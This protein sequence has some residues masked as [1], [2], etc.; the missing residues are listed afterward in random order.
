MLDSLDEIG[1]I[2][3]AV[4]HADEIKNGTADDPRGKLRQA[5]PKLRR[6]PREQARTAW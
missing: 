2:D 6:H 1:R 5:V 4:A 3:P